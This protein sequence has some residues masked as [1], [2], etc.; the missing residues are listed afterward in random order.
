MMEIQAMTR[1][2]LLALLCTLG[3]APKVSNAQG[4]T[5]AG[6]PRIEPLRLSDAEWKKR[7]S[8]EQY[9]VLRHEGTERPGSSPLN[10]EHRKGRYHCA[11]CELPLFSSET[12]FD[13]GTGWPSFYAALPGAIATKTDFKLVVP[14]TEYHCARCEGHQGHV[15]NDGPRPTGKRYCNNGVA[16]KFVPSPS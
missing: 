15:F 10:G 4:P 5:P 11:G 7:L 8:A 12:K 1:R 2:P 14:R 9:A 16:L 13:S 3:L 6:T